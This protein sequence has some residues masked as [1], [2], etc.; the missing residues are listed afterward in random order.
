LLIMFEYF[1]EG[2]ATESAEIVRCKREREY[3][4]DRRDDEKQIAS[5]TE[6]SS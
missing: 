2:I 3:K 6:E 1:P 4:G 5:P